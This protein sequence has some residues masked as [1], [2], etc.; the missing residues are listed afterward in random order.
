MEYF[1]KDFGK[2][3]KNN[4]QEMRHSLLPE[5][6]NCFRVYDRNLS[7]FPVTVDIYG[8]YAKVVDYGEDEPLSDEMR[9]TCLDICARMLYLEPGN[10][11][12]SYRAKREQ[13][14]QHEKTQAD[15]LVVDVLEN[16]LRF[17][18]DL[19]TYVDTG[20][21]LDH[22]LTR[23]LVR[24]RSAG[25]DVLNLF[26]YTGSFSV[27]AAAGLAN[28]V[29]SVDLSATYTRWA[30]ENLAA[31]GYE[32]PSYECVCMDASKYIAEAAERNEKYDIIVFD[33][34]SF[35]NSRKMD[36]DFDVARDYAD[37]IRNLAKLMKKTGVILFSTNLGTFRMDRRR[38]R[39]MSVK[40]ITG[41]VEAPGFVRGRKGAVRSWMMA[42]DD[43]SLKLD[44]SEPKEESKKGL[45]EK[46]ASDRGGS[47]K[48]D[49]RRRG[50]S[51]SKDGDGYRGSRD[52]RGARDYRGSD[53]GYG[54]GDDRRGGYRER[55]GRSG[56]YRGGDR[57]SY[58]RDRFDRDFSDRRR[59]DD[60]RPRFRDDGEDRSERRGYGSDRHDGFRGER[61]SDG[62]GFRHDDRRDDRRD[63]RQ[64]RGYSGYSSDR[65]GGSYRS[66]KQ[67]GYDRPRYDRPRY[68]RDDDRPRSYEGRERSSQG[69]S[70]ERGQ[71]RSF[72]SPRRS[73]DD[74][75]GRRS[76]S[77]EYRG[78]RDDRSEG[79]GG[80]GRDDRFAKSAKSAKKPYGFDSFKPARSRDD[81][82][83]FFWNSDDLDV[84]PKKED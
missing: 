5:G 41:A 68:D 50:G 3:L 62:R 9:A 72:D 11:V 83:D 76:S 57:P 79:F 69:R 60:Y 45:D 13:G 38:L 22:R 28:S 52:A 48:D 43:D 31:N 84:K 18:V 73:G 39:G 25:C 24:D 10:I 44:W 37:W 77:S 1:E 82:S 65:S 55:D 30:Q 56:G 15:S 67:D 70:W 12:Y 35:S 42:F 17:K 26:S 14:Q 64:G 66:S 7:Q 27:Y 20:L 47:R 80:R 53:R 16:D 21:F 75:S 33:P 34:P 54:R 49:D 8:K 29:R 61:R 36:G 2:I 81:S 51:Y 74:Y 40:E 46:K 19:T 58:Q 6:T 63:D 59:S 71:G 78:R 32:G 23:M 4:A